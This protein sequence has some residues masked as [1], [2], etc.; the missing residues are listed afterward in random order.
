M[1]YLEGSEKLN[2]WGSALTCEKILAKVLDSVIP[3]RSRFNHIGVLSVV[4]SAV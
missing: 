1:V 4:L 2:Y 3:V